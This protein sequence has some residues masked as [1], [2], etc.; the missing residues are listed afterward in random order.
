MAAIETI[1]RDRFQRKR[2]P[3]QWEPQAWRTSPNDRVDRRSLERGATLDT[4]RPQ[5]T[6]LD[7]TRPLSPCQKIALLPGVLGLSLTATGVPARS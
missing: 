7:R 5:Q 3:M 2:A 6:S 4:P 1:E